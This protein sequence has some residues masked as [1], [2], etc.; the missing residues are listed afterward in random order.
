MSGMIVGATVVTS[1][2]ISFAA[3]KSA[4]AQKIGGIG[5]NDINKAL[6][7][8]CLP[9][10][11]FD[12]FLNLF[13]ILDGLDGILGAL[14]NAL[15]GIL[16]GFNNNWDPTKCLP[17]LPN[18]N[19]NPNF[20]AQCMAQIPIPTCSFPTNFDADQA[21]KNCLSGLGNY[22]IPNVDLEQMA[23]CAIPN[24]PNIDLSQLGGLLQNI[25]DQLLNR[26]NALDGIFTPKNINLANW[27]INFCGS[28]QKGNVK[29]NVTSKGKK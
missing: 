23:Q 24:V 12:G 15:S 2:S 3:P 13:S 26:L 29:V 5:K 8:A 28:V 25:L 6:K 20:L 22:S 17:N 27:F 1:P 4:K 9:G 7:Q 10:G 21:L 11:L 18:F 16:G 14:D 19:F